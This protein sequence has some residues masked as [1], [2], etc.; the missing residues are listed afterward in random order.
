[1][2]D[3]EL[4]SKIRPAYV[5]IS[6]L[7]AVVG[8]FLASRLGVYGTVIGVG[9]I[10]L[11]STLGTELSLRSLD[12]T[13]QAAARTIIR[14]GEL[15]S[16]S[17]VITPAVPAE[18]MTA[19]AALADSNAVDG[20]TAELERISTATLDQVEG[21]ATAPLEAVEGDV[22]AGAY[23]ADL[24]GNDQRGWRRWTTGRV[25]V[26]ATGAVASFVLALLVVTGI[27]SVSGNSFSGGGRTTLGQLVVGGAGTAEPSD[28]AS[29]GDAPQD[30]PAPSPERVAPSPGQAESPDTAEP[31]NEGSSNA[32]EPSPETSEEPATRSSPEPTQPT[33][34]EPTEPPV[35][36]DGDEGSQ[37][38]PAQSGDV[39]TQDDAP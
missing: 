32:R 2:A 33:S 18:G 11:V 26:I 37:T 24:T 9:V 38:D 14:T 13:R 7:A 6:S 30:A 39:S 34:P 4:T 28:R 25:P 12:R 17:T 19:T 22:P 5:L 36:G 31:E 29:G 16:S 21:D 1:M 23:D 15:P 27:E 20:D 3:A 10:S 35:D 8:A